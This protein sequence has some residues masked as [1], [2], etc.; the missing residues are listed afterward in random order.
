[1]QFKDAD[2]ETL[3]YLDALWRR[4]YI[5]YMCILVMPV[6]AIL[7]T[8][9]IPQK[10][11]A[12]TSIA[13]NMN[14]LPAMKDINTPIDIS[15][16][17]QSLKAFVMAPATLQQ[18]AIDTKLIS[19]KAS[20]STINGT[21]SD[22]SK[23]LT[24]ELLDKS[25]IQIQL[26]QYSPKHVVDILNSI[27]GM[28]IKQFNS[29][30]SSTSNASLNMLTTT[31]E[32]Q[33]QK[34]KEAIAALNK[35][36]SAN[37]DL[38]PEYKDLYQNQLRLI[39]TSLGEKKAIY[40]SIKAEKE[41]LE[42]SLLKLNPVAAQLERAILENS[43]KLSKLRLV[44]TDNYP[45]VKALIQLDKSLK[46]E[47][48]QLQKQ[49]KNLDKDKMQQL[50]DLASSTTNNSNDKGSTALLGTQLEKLLD[51]QLKL[52][53]MTEEIAT[54][55]EQ[56]KD[57]NKKLQFIIDN[58]QMITELKQN[59]KDNRTAY[60]DL[61]SRN[62]LAKM[63]VGYNKDE[64][65]QVIRVIAYPETPSTSLSRPLS[66]FIFL[67]IIAGIIFGISIPIVMELLDNRARNSRS[68]EAT[69]GFEVLCRV[70]RLS[71]Q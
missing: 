40:M 4:R 5:T 36:Q 39:N 48:D 7:S 54:L 47:R 9:L 8:Y 2:Y 32:V 62:N 28:M 12:S 50:W 69:T 66:F 67:G 65:S 70:E 10:Y 43:I 23:N 11:K 59:I 58:N 3:I 60:E 13:V 46:D 41:E 21:V 35:Y 22:L 55:T 49:Y 24:I 16:E 44:Y 56:E 14:A 18:V 53:G 42:Q 17:F 15:N 27:S 25:V 37:S 61:L 1:M 29:Q 26:I 33:K 6:L 45:E 68:V 52:K 51:M 64:K 71:F 20:K 30:E 38:L 57:V 34:L 31:L 63:S 19:A